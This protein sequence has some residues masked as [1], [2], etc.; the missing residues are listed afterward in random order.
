[1]KKSSEKGIL[2]NSSRVS[3]ELLRFPSSPPSDIDSLVFFNENV[4]QRE[5]SYDIIRS[6]LK[7]GQVI[8][9]A[10]GDIV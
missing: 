6:T 9:L 5:N 3:S 4:R 7:R 8:T 1:M 10:G 2:S